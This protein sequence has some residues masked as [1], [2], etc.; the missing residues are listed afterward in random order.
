M[1]D[2]EKLIIL[3]RDGVIN[4]DSENYIKHPD[5]WI[6]IP[7]SLSAIARL[8]QVG[9]QVVIATNQSG[10]D[11]GYYSLDILE[12]IHE[13]MRRELAKAGGRVTDI[14][15]CPH[16]PQANCPCRKPKPGLLDLIA[17]DFPKKLKGSTLVGDSL[18]DIQAARAVGC[19]PVL[20]KTGNG[21]KTVANG[22]GLEDVPIF[23]DLSDFVNDLTRK[24]P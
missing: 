14:Y 16:V 24:S 17:E 18:G 5:E 4:Y 22:E 12:A 6:P 10:V 1:S 15:F 21:E 7:G 3:D 23:E 20:V 13:K 9:Y 11:R 19:L 2:E 8:N